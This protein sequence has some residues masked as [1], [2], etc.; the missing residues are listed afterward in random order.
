M[1]S[2]DRSILKFDSHL[3]DIASETC[4]QDHP[5]ASDACADPFEATRGALTA[6]LDFPAMNAAIVPGDHVAIAVDPNTPQVS[7]VLAGVLQ[8][9]QESDAANVSVVI[10]DE[11]CGS[12]V[13]EIESV[14]GDAAQVELHR[15]SDRE[16]LR[17]LGPDASGNPMYLNRWLV[18][19]DFVL[20]IMSGRS[21]DLDRQHDLYGFFPAF[22]DTASRL[23]LLSPPPEAGVETADPNEPAWALGA[24]LILCVT[25]STTGEVA[26]VVAGTVDSIRKRL[27]ETRYVS[28]RRSPTSLVVASLDGDHQQ[29]TWQNVARAAAA[30][31]RVSDSGGTIV[32]WTRLSDAPSGHLLSLTEPSVVLPSGS[33]MLT[34]DEFPSWDPMLAPAETLRSLIQDYRVLLRS[35]LTP[36]QTESIGIGHIESSEELSKLTRSFSACKILRAA[37]FCGSTHNWPETK[38]Q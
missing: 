36:E 12:T 13:T 32:L 22:S 35:E 16:S 6:P 38:I 25:S 17:F 20:P 19:A 34:E 24:Q 10:G 33:Q 23:H 27:Q 29:Q 2:L 15:P 9:L 14:V 21:G 7:R 26:D 18:D 30:A 4:V 8:S 3:S 31:A 28:Q 1:S 11:A 5:V 37:S